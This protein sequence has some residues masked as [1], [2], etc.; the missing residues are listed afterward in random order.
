VPQF[1]LGET[2]AKREA[3]PCRM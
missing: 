3:V 2:W 1:L